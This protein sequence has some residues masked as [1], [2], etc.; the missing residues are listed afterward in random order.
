MPFIPRHRARLGINSDSIIVSSFDFQDFYYL[1]S[2][3]SDDHFFYLDSGDCSV[4][5]GAFIRMPL[6]VRVDELD[7]LA[8]V[9][10]RKL[11]D[12]GWRCGRSRGILMQNGWTRFE[13]SEI[14]D[15]SASRCLRSAGDSSEYRVWLSQANH[16]LSRL[17][18][19]DDYE[20]Y[21]LVNGIDFTLHF[22][23]SPSNGYLF[24]CPLEDFKTS[25]GLLQPPEA[26]SYWSHNPSGT[27]RLSPTESINCGFPPPGLKIRVSVCSWESSCYLALRRFHIAKGFN[28]DSQD[29]AI[30]LGYPLYQ[31]CPRRELL[32]AYGQS[33]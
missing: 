12:D 11:L 10:N 14:S 33:F 32:F 2:V 24:L 27:P 28:P 29:V 7:Q 21:G 25:E 1:L 9:P 15:L 4:Q 20:E 8:W 23:Q 5:L 30:Q 31:I 17:Q 13:A 3:L 19:T 26:P 18:I 16:I 6:S 22:P